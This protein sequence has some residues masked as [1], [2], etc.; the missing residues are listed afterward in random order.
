M[1]TKDDAF[2]EIL[3]P[4]ALEILDPESKLEILSTGHIWSEGPL[5]LDKSHTLLFTDIPDNTIYQV[6]DGVSSIYLKPSGYTGDVERGGEIGANGLT[7]DLQGKLVMCQHGDRRMA[8]MEAPL[9]TPAPAFA[10]LVDN[11]GGKR[12]NSPND[13]VFDR[14]GN[15]YFTDPPYGLEYNMDDPAKELDFQGVYCLKTSGELALLD[16]ISRPNGLAFSPDEKYFY[17]ANSDPEQAVWFRYDV[18]EKGLIHNRS[19]FFDATSFVGKAGYKGL[20]D[21]MKVHSSGII[22]ATGPG[23]VWIFD[24]EGKPL[25]RIATGEA[26]SNCTLSTD[27]KTLFMT[28]HSYVLKVGLK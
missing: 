23:G 7:L 26:T 19:L 15:M 21:G 18:G 16:T 17:L 6:K 28:A 14:A 12:L 4:A 13:V 22:F 3:D 8:R 27:Q 2:I 25:A 1:T 11:F 10:T 9:D 20:P 24:P 5:W